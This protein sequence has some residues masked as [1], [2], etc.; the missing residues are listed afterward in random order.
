M[1]MKRFLYMGFAFF[2]AA[3]V[4]ACGG[5]GSDSGGGGGTNYIAGDMETYTAGGVS[6]SMAYIPGGLTF[7]TGE[8]D[9]GTATVARAYWIGETEV[10]Y[11]LWQKVYAW[12]ITNG[13][14]VFANA[15][16]EGRN[17]TPGAVPTTAKYE[18][19]TTVNWRDC[20][21]WCN[22]LTEWYNAQ[23]GTSFECVYTYS[24]AIIRDSRDS[25]ATACDGVVAS[26]TAK[27]FRLLTSNEWELAAR[28]RRNATNVVTGTINGVDFSAMTV[29]WTKGDS[30]SGAYE[31][32]NNAPATGLVA[33][34]DA[35]SGFVATAVKSKTANALSLYDLSG[36]VWE[37]CFDLSG[38][39][40]LL[41]GGGWG[42]PADSLIVGFWAVDNPSAKSS[43]TGLRIAR[44]E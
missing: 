11:E 44:T 31:G 25:N 41:R 23:K 5:G 3:F 43:D 33:V 34:Y 22:A 2:I 21:V 32:Y 37:R 38:S 12:A 24:N 10:T 4:I 42:S 7:P 28:Y 18:P 16:C 27:G 13:G 8:N 35:N 15:G 20:I 19:V 29:K 6:F 26:I 39:K 14:Y 1:F 9:D 30:A 17:G 40:R 36:N